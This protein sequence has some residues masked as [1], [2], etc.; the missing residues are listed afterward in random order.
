MKKKHSIEVEW[1]RISV[2][3]CEFSRSRAVPGLFE[4]DKCFLHGECEICSS[5]DCES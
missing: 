1:G 5:L 4:Q 3:S 2:G